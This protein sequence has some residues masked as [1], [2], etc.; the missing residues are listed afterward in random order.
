MF[1][2]TD[3]HLAA[4]AEY[5]SDWHGA[6]AYYEKVI[7]ESAPLN[8]YV[9]EWYRGTA[10]YGIARASARLN[11]PVRVRSAMTF[12]FEHHFWNFSLVRLD[13]AVMG[14]CGNAWIDSA[15]RFW[16]AVAQ[17]EQRTWHPQPPIIFYPNGYD[18]T[19]NWPLIVAM[20]GGN[21]NYENFS[22]P[23]RGLADQV[24]AIIVFPPGIIRESEV[25]NTWES[26]MDRIDSAIEGLVHYFTDRGLAD[27]KEVYLTGFS[28]GAQASIEL[29]LLHPNLFRGAIALSGFSSKLFSDS[30][31]GA[32]RRQ[33]VHIYAMSGEFE[34][35]QFLQQIQD[36]HSRCAAASIPFNLQILSGM[37]HEVPLDIRAQFLTAWHFVHPD[38]EASHQRG[39]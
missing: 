14:V 5:H 30:I 3:W 13:S 34:D 22:E 27:P 21:G 1:V 33:D 9:R 8:I 32:A 19:K 4:I 37:T 7:D 25:T 20:H 18:S 24:R 2:R 31:F 38:S 6:I 26:R 39:E 15:A 23:W 17:E 12:A 11:D 28:Q 16:N 10:G 29:T 36:I 35:S